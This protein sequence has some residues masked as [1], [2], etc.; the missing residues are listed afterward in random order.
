[1]DDLYVDGL[2]RVSSVCTRARSQQ[3]FLDLILLVQNAGRGLS[4]RVIAFS[5]EM[6][7][8]LRY[9]AT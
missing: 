6:R 2:V 3:Y 5:M 1:M 4:E 8:G 7:A 9:A